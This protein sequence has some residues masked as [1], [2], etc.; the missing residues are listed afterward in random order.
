[1]YVNNTNYTCLIREKYYAEWIIREQRGILWAIT[2]AKRQKITLRKT[3]VFLNRRNN[4]S[5]IAE[6]LSWFMNKIILKKTICVFIC[7][8]VD[9]TYFCRTF[10][11]ILQNTHVICVD[12]FRS[13]FL[14]IVFFLSTIIRILYFTNCAIKC[15]FRVLKELHCQDLVIAQQQVGLSNLIEPLTKK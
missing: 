13:N 15:C 8:V 5:Y 10:N 2:C 3:L 4:M 9:V 12:I 1:M 7:I 11:L 14:H 6:S